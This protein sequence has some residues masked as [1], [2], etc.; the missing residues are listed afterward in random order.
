MLLQSPARNAAPEGTVA[1]DPS[2]RPTVAGLILMIDGVALEER[3]RYSS[4]RNQIIGL[5]REHSASV[6][7]LVTGLD[8]IKQVEAA[9]HGL[10]DSPGPK[11]CYGKDGTV[12]AI[13]PYARTD[14][15]TPVPILLSP[16]CKSETG[17][18]LVESVRVVSNTWHIHPYG[19]QIHGSLW[20]LGSDGE[21]SF[22]RARFLL[23]M[24]EQLDRDAPL[25]QLLHSLP[26]FNCYTGARGLVGTCD[27]KH[28]IKRKS[29]SFDS[30]L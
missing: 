30:V 17:E 11:C 24:S 29:T 27:P 15:Y 1:D 9:L 6:P 2:R 18:E 23:C 4:E 10:P 16:S 25:G 7:T 20:S 28:V 26:G 13:A 12:A 22:R 8:V 21:S 3:C 19:E 5:C 14:H